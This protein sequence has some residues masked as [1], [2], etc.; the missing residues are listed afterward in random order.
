MTV[1]AEIDVAEVWEEVKRADEA[2][3]SGGAGH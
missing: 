3:R 1:K 2:G